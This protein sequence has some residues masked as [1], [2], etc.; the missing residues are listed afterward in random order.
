MSR[1][2]A[3]TLIELLV[4]LAIIAIL[5]G[6]LVPAVQKVRAAAAR[7]QCLSQLR[8]IGIAVHHYHDAR[9][10]LPPAGVYPPSG[11][12]AWSV[13]ARLLP[14]IEQD[15]LHRQINFAASFTT[16]PAVTQTRIPL[17]MCPQ[18]FSDRPQPG[19]NYYPTSYGANYG[20]WM[21]W[22]PATGKSGD[23]AFIVNGSLRLIGFTDGTSNTL[24]FAEI[25]SYR[26]LFQ[27]SGQPQAAGAPP[28]SNPKTV[29][30]WKGDFVGGGHSQWVDAR[31]HQTGFTT[32]FG[33]NAF[34][35]YEIPIYNQFQQIVG[36]DVYEIDYT[37][38]REGSS[39]TAIT[40]A[41]V[42][43]HG[44]HDGQINILM[45]DASARTVSSSIAWDTWRALGTRAGGETVGDF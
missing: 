37:S 39:A 44:H 2:R 11:G 4:V 30:D 42:T 9:K 40:Y 28:P 12:D 21:I 33:P 41:V 7:T 13:H 20:T 16:Q 31:V 23:G 15:P 25:R 43:A 35:P 5:I 1:R 36:Y 18:D 19:S 22:N 45:M 3:F 34:V 10:S 24:A 6:L 38:M 8:Q 29:Q 32:T 14:Y 26:N 17:Y 27:D